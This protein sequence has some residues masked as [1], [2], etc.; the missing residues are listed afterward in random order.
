MLRDGG[1][2]VSQSPLTRA[3]RQA[4]PVRFSN[5][6]AVEQNAISRC[7]FGMFTL[8]DHTGKIDARHHGEASHDGPF[9]GDRQG[10][11][12]VERAPFDANLDVTWGKR[13]GVKLGQRGLAPLIGFG[14]LYE[15][16]VEHVNLLSIE[17]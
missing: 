5:T 1:S 15:N 11:L 12:V 7:P 16:G 2:R 13:V 6:P 17:R 4:A 3:L 14:L 9:T 10:V 8:L